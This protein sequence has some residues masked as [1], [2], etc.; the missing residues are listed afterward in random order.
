MAPQRPR[1]DDVVWALGFVQPAMRATFGANACI[2][3]TRVA[4]EVLRHSGVRV[5]PLAVHVDVFNPPYVER[6]QA[7]D[8]DPLR[9]PRCWSARLGFTGEPQTGDRV[10]MH[11]VAIVED[12]LVLDLTLDQCSTPEHDVDLPPGVFYGLPRG[13]V[14]GGQVEYMVNG[15]AV[16]YEAHP[17][18]RGYL[19]APDWTDR[20]RRQRFVDQTLARLASKPGGSARN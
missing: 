10:D 18:E 16:V 14:R 19:A 1:T 17:D 11:V 12:R 8:D 20:V 3:A 4:V 7:G 9:D 13:F 6:A 2:V 15:C 5:Q